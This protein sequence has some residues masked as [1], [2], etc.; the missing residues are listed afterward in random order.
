MSHPSRGMESTQWVGL[1]VF[2]SALVTTL[3]QTL[4]VARSWMK[5]LR[6]CSKAA[7]S[8]PQ[9]ELRQEMGKGRGGGRQGC[10]VLPIGTLGKRD[11]VKT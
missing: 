9:L 5:V 2:A 3:T 11:F 6:Y 10:R 1:Q 4:L 7:I 8:A